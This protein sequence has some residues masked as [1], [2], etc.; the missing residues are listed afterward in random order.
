MS[1]PS[2]LP[3]NVAT[4]SMAAK[5][6][7]PPSSSRVGRLASSDTLEAGGFTPGVV[8]AE[9]YRI[10]GLLGRG[11][12]GEV[13]R[14][15]D[16]K[17]GQP[18]ALKFLPERFAAEKDRL[19][20]FYAEVRIARQVSHPNVCRVY[21]VGEIHGRHYLS[22]EYVDGEDLASLL[23]RIGRLPPDKALEISRELCAGLSAAHDRGVLHRD[24]KPAN[25][26]VDGRG[27]ARIT[28]FGLA[29][30]ASDVVE[31]EVSGTPAYM[32][33]E[34]LA[35]KGASVRSDVYALGLVLYELSTGRKV[36][37][38]ASLDELR[39]KHTEEAPT[40]PSTVAPGFD[41][42]VERVIL[43]CLEKDPAARPS[44][45][46]QIAAALPGGDPLAAALAAGETP[47]P[48]MV[49]AAGERGAISPSTARLLL[50]FVA[51]LLALAIL[52]APRANIASFVGVDKSPEILRERAREILQ[53]AGIEKSVDWAN[54]FRTDERFL[55]WARDHGGVGGDL[56]R[57][58]IAFAYRQSPS[59]LVPALAITGPFPSPWVTHD[60]PPP[61]A[62]GMAEVQVDARG[63]LIRLEVVPPEV[64]DRA[65]G[66]PTDWSRLFRQAG[67]D[68][69]RF[70]PVEPEWSPLAFATERAAWEGPH[71]ERR[72][73][74]MRVEAASYAGRPVSFR[75]VGPWTPH[76]RGSAAS[77]AS[78]NGE[79]VF[80]AILFLCILGGGLLARHNLRSGRS[81]RSGALRFAVAIAA[82][83]LLMWVLGGHHVRSSDEG[84]L[85]LEAFS[86]AA[87]TGLIYWIL[88]V[89]LEPYARRRWPEMLI[90]WQRALS[91]RWRDP[92]V[93]RAALIGAV[94]GTAA[95]LIVGPARVLLPVEL[96]VPGLLP[97][98]LG[99]GAPVNAGA[100]VAWRVSSATT[101]TFWV[102]GI[103]FILVLVRRLVRSEWLAGLIVTLIFSGPY[104]EE[105]RGQVLVLPLAVISV[106]IVVFTTVR[107]G[108]L[109]AI[110]AEFCGRLVTY[111]F[112]SGDPSNWAFYAGMV[113]VLVIAALAAWGAKTALA[114]RPLFG[115]GE[116]LEEA[117]AGSAR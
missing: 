4:P 27:R 52:F 105:S 107:F 13:Y 83:T 74:T 103:V 42:A 108:V 77:L 71:P 97:M 67:L 55:A 39:R 66:A 99:G 65:V 54:W 101:S 56:S 51:G 61:V 8:F 50:L 15:D 3:T 88:Y 87:G 62:P 96:G 17:L 84:W 23:K 92:L 91:G 22:M 18:V 115:D 31:G 10:I 40:A 76:Q 85:F 1:S 28:D 7:R 116:M 80:E 114:G 63:R 57:D 100:T 113:G 35:G 43:R 38:G 102:L 70:A 46:A 64:R 81:D 98:P 33:P 53:D 75:W 95:G 19:E 45:V 111:H 24:L 36:F 112:V 49:A 94:V 25:V 2:Q 32:A 72:G 68:M 90:S 21:D 58:A 93:G 106:A 69:S 48:E 5:A 14:A 26:M 82:L 73:V 104:I 110:V 20:R 30:A 16:L 34:Q 9:R 11:G 109:A 86:N 12:M 79:I 6:Q 78:T 60:N 41:P 89:A 59:S 37:D 44:S 47:S 29:V 117:R